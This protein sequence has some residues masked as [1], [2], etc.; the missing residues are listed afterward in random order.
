MKDRQYNYQHKKDRRTNNDLQY[1]TQNT[2]DWTTGIP[3][4]PELSSGA[5]G[6]WVVPVLYVTPVV[7]FLLQTRWE[8]INEERVGLWLRQTE[9]IRR[10]LWRI[11]SVTDNRVMMATV[12]HS[13]WWLE[14]TKK[15]PFYINYAFL[16][17]FLFRP[18][19]LWVC[20]CGSWVSNTII[21]QSWLPN[22]HTLY[23]KTRFSDN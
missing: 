4:N 2:K 10:H 21:N 16:N 7:L 9:H 3:Q 12:K 20:L 17:P 23:I 14:L 18:F 11:Y 8:V 13:K 1:I 15:N 6:G 5:P 19:T 22:V